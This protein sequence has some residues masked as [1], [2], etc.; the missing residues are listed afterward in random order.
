M[1]QQAVPLQERA[2]P[3]QQE[4]VITPTV[5]INDL[6]AQAIS[7]MWDALTAVQ[8]SPPGFSRH[9]QFTAAVKKMPETKFSKIEATVNELAD[10]PAAK[11]VELS[12]NPF[13]V[14]N[15]IKESRR[16]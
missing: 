12:S 1:I 16:L 15:D 9:D 5:D 4:A 11:P 10:E 2:E 14:P 7:P 8:A 3:V 6:I 13:N